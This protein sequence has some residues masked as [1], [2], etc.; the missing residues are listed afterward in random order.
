MSKFTLVYP[1]GFNKSVTFLV[2]DVAVDIFE[3]GR[4]TRRV[5]K[6][7]ARK[8]YREFLDAGFKSM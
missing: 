2:S 6:D 5:T 4:R 7:A 1:R 3:S 8:Y